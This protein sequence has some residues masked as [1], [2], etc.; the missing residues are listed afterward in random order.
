MYL[1]PNQS[2]L[3]HYAHIHTN[4]QGQ[5]GRIASLYFPL[6]PLILN[7]VS[8]LDTGSESYISPMLNAASM[9]TFK[10]SESS[11]FKFSE[12]SVFSNSGSVPG[13]ATGSE[14]WRVG[15]HGVRVRSRISNRQ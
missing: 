14:L 12:G 3:P 11:A 10:T 7:H 6:I 8:R 13:S 15:V 4:T 1:L 9:A 5:R 2:T